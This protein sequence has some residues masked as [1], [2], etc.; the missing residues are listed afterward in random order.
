MGKC[1]I[2]KKKEK[3]TQYGSSKNISVRN[4]ST[5]TNSTPALLSG[6]SPLNNM[7]TTQQMEIIVVAKQTFDDVQTLSISW[8]NITKTNIK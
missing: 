7:N 5:P 1:K 8:I 3:K 4:N 6:T 2:S